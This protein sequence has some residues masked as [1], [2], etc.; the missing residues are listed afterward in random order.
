MKKTWT[1]CTRRLQTEQDRVEKLST[2]GWHST[3]SRSTITDIERRR[4]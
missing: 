1:S 2:Q 3:C 4:R